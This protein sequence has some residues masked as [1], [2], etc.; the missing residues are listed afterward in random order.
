MTMIELPIAA[1]IGLTLVLIGGGAVLGY[2]ICYARQQREGGGR[3]PAEL[4]RD[5]DSYQQRVSTH[6]ERSAVLFHDLTVRYR[7]LYQHMAESAEAL[8]T[9]GGDARERLRFEELARL[10]LQP[11]GSD[12]ADPSGALE[13]AT[14]TL[15]PARAAGEPPTEAS[16]QAEPRA[17]AA[18]GGRAPAAPDAGAEPARGETPAD[19]GAEPR[20]DADPTPGV[21]EQP[22]TVPGA[23]RRAGAAGEDRTEADAGGAADPGVQ[24]DAEAGG[25]VPAGA[26]TAP[27]RKH[28]TGARHA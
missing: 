24:P 11:P 4:R 14:F 1:V 16:E 17:G 27:P 5:L 7:E 18:N 8:G 2:V 13:R 19:G 10:A 21:D 12:D 22:H 9:H 28:D 15:D 20:A 3:T 25:T 26:E 6:F 23:G